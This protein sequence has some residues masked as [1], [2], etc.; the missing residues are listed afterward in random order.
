MFVPQAEA[1][2]RARPGGSVVDALWK[3]APPAKCDAV[4]S[5]PVWIEK[6]AIDTNYP[7]R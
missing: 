3:W 5:G 1:A 7:S 2:V 4:H 6:G